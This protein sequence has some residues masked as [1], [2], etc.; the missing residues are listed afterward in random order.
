MPCFATIRRA[1]SLKRQHSASP[2]FLPAWRDEQ[3]R[4]RLAEIVSTISKPLPFEFTHSR[5]ASP[6]ERTFRARTLRIF[7]T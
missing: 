3:A 4:Y 7:P 2:L 5:A 6:I 1:V